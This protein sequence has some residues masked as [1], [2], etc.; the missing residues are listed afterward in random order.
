VEASSASTS[1][2]V[3]VEGVAVSTSAIVR[4]PLWRKWFR[5]LGEG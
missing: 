4:L 3:I 1:R 5:Q 2:G